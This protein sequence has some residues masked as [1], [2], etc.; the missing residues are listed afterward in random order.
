MSRWRPAW[1]VWRDLRR[2]WEGSAKPK[3]IGKTGIENSGKK[4]VRVT[5]EA[6]Q[7]EEHQAVGRF[8][9][10]ARPW[11][12]FCFVDKRRSPDHKGERAVAV[13]QEREHKRSYPRLAVGGRLTGR[14]GHGPQI[15]VVDLSL[16]GV[17]IEHPSFVEPEKRLN[18]E[19]VVPRARGNPEVPSTPIEPP[20]FRG[21]ADRSARADLSDG[22]RVSRDLRDIPPAS[23]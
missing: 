2:R 23:Y 1:K 16:G 7:S 11:H 18:P 21:L 20:A 19:R 10:E 14:I 5:S 13:E 3:K 9:D 17:L 12:A 22:A 6:A 15:F 8:T 4:S